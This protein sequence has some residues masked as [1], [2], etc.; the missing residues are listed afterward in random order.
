MDAMTFLPLILIECGTIING[1]EN[2]SSK[3]QEFVMREELINSDFFKN[4]PEEV[5]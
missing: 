4:L 2:K 5:K 3:K 1:L